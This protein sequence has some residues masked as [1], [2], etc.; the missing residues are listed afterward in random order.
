MELMPKYFW[1]SEW[2]TS[3]KTL[4]FSILLCERHDYTK[5]K[6]L[7]RLRKS[8]KTEYSVLIVR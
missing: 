8:K 2:D 1:T 6:Q 5:G 7:L 4:R 3:I